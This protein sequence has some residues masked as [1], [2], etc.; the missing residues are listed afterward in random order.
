MENSFHYSDTG[1]A[2]QG[3]LLYLEAHFV[4]AVNEMNSRAGESIHASVL[5][6]LW[7]FFFFPLLFLLCFEKKKPCVVQPVCLPNYLFI[8]PSPVPASII[9]IIMW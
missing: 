9:H 2:K 3:N 4:I 5:W 7:L 6:M 8:F 1:E